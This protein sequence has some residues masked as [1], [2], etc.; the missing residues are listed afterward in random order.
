M[1]LALVP[2]ALV[3]IGVAPVHRLLLQL[4]I[5]REVLERLGWL[6]VRSAVQALDRRL[7]PLGDSTVQSGIDSRLLNRREPTT[8]PGF[9]SLGALRLIAVPGEL[10]I[11]PGIFWILALLRNDSTARLQKQ[12]W[13]CVTAPGAIAT[14]RKRRQIY[15]ISR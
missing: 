8:D 14:G 7:L 2:H 6:R 4:G 10:A 3:A 5:S 11:P 1:R 9:R 13:R 12:G 15:E